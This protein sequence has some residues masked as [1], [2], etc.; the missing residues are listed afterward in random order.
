ML[1]QVE[2]KCV[3]LLKVSCVRRAESVTEEAWKR[4]H[5]IDLCCLIAFCGNLFHV[6]AL[7][8]YLI[9]LTHFRQQR[10]QQQKP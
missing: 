2:P 6:V 10:H 7:R 5:L 3:L 4:R 8:K 9:P 1:G